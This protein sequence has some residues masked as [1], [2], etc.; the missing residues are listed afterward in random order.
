MLPERS[1][2]SHEPLNRL[3]QDFRTMDED[4]RYR[5]ARLFSDLPADP[6]EAVGRNVFVVDG[7]GDDRLSRDELERLNLRRE[8]M[9]R[10][11]GKAV[12]LLPRRSVLE[13]DAMGTRRREDLESAGIGR[14]EE[15]PL[16]LDQDHFGF[17]VRPRRPDGVLD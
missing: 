15:A 13:N 7:D 6:I 12:V 17:L 9:N 8:R 14:I 10:K 3:D 16:P 11:P 2:L 4:V 1:S 5:K